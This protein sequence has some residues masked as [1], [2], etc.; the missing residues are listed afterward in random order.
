MLGYDRRAELQ[1]GG[2]NCL[3]LREEQ[4]RYVAL[5]CRNRLVLLDRTMLIRLLWQ[6]GKIKGTGVNMLWVSSEDGVGLSRVCDC[7]FLLFSLVPFL[8]DG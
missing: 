5:L 3:F 6:E 1:V 4:L 2:T 7:L 8:G